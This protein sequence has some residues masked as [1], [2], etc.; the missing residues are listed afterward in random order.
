MILKRSIGGLIVAVAAYFCLTSFDFWG[1]SDTAYLGISLVLG[2]LFVLF[3]G[4]LWSWFED[5]FHWS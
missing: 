5:I 3:G 2:L 4:P 1:L